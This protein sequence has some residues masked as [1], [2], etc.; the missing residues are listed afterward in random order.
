MP[1]S[2]FTMDC[3]VVSWTPLASLPTKRVAEA[4]AVHGDDFADQELLQP[5]IARPRRGGL[6]PRV[7]VEGNVAELP[8]DVAP[9]AHDIPR[10]GR[11]GK[12]A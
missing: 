2:H 5:L 1:T 4:P 3:K 11:E 7:E 10:N 12:A 8:N 6:P 9:V